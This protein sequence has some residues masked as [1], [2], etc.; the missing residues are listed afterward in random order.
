MV[1]YTDDITPSIAV[2]RE[3]GLLIYP[4]DTVWG[5]GCDATNAQAVEKIFSLKQRP[6]QKS[7]IVLLADAHELPKYVAK[8]PENIIPLLESF[9]TPT[10]VIY[11]GAMHLAANAIN[12]DGSIAIRIVQDDFCQA[13]IRQFGRPI[14]STSANLSGQAT[15]ALF[16]DIASQLLDGVDY[17]VKH[18]QDDPVPRGASRIVTMDTEGQLVYI[19]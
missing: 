12:E 13:L 18:R 4:T 16:K 1:D 8:L 7:M 6:S 15:P 5:I 17:I 2:L 19:R 11:Q 3:G 10:T 9:T 14:I